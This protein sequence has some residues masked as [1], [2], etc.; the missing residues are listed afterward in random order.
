MKGIT[1]DKGVLGW[2]SNHIILL[3]TSMSCGTYK[4]AMC[5]ILGLFAPCAFLFEMSCYWYQV[6]VFIGQGIHCMSSGEPF[7]LWYFCMAPS[8]VG[9]C[10]PTSPC[11]TV[12]SCLV[13]EISK[14]CV[15]SC[16]SKSLRQRHTGAGSKDILNALSLCVWHR[17]DS[18]GEWEE[19]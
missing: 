12:L 6:T 19:R 10:K 9:H 13:V 16:L 8:A 7:M 11:A 18:A 1:K 15:G 5:H 17:Q 4:C 2:R 3:H 14:E